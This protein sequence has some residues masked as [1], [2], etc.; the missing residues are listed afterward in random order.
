MTFR[1]LT[2][3]DFDAVVAAFNEAF[4][5]YAVRFSMT[6]LQLREICARRAVVFELSVGAFDGDHLVGFT[7]NGFDGQT[8]YDSGTGVIPSHRRQGLARGMMEYI[9]PVLCDAGARQYLLE[10]IESNSRA[11]ALYESLGFKT[12]REF[13]CWKF[14][15]N[16]SRD[17]S[18]R[19]IE[20]DQI[21]NFRDVEPSWQNSDAA[22][23][24]AL[25]PRTILG[26]FDGDLLTGYAVVFPRTHDLAQLAIRRTHRRRGIG[27]ALL[28]C[29]AA[30]AEGT[31]RILNVDASDEGIDA[32]LRARGSEQFIRQREMARLL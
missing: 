4:S 3:D 19:P 11:V 9:L 25:D 31:V 24:R 22:I 32:F 21:E 10:V 8:A 7:L 26:A 5:D 16:G 23:R 12:T 14:E 20:L 30:E 13:T 15:S 28:E 1:T 27:S 29:A 6:A 17:A 18:I 2:G